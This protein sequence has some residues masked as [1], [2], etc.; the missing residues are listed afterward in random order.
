MAYV[1]QTT[2]Y[3]YD[4]NYNRLTEIATENTGNTET[5]N[6]TFSYNNRNQITDITD[7]RDN[8]NNVVFT[9][10]ENGNRTTKVQNTTTT[11]FDYDIRD[12]IKTITQGGSSVGQFLYDWQGLRIKK[13]TQAETLRYVYDDQSVLVQT[14][15]TG[16]TISKYDYGPDRLLSLNNT[17]EGTQ[18]YLFDA[19]GS[20]VNLI[21]PDGSLQARYQYDAWGNYRSTTGT[22]KNAFGFT[23]HE[24]DEETSLYYA[25]ARFYDPELGLFLNEDPFEGDPLTP[26]SLHRYTYAFANPTVYID[27]NGRE[28]TAFFN[29]QVHPETDILPT[30]GTFDSGFLPLDVVNATIATP[31][32]F[33]STT[34][35]AISAGLAS[36]LIV[37][38]QL[39]GRSVESLENEA[40]ALS[41]STGPLAPFVFAGTLPS[42]LPGTLSRFSRSLRGIDKAR[43]TAKTTPSANQ[44][45]NIADDIPQ[46]PNG[47]SS[48]T[49][50]ESSTKAGIETRRNIDGR[51]IDEKT[52]RFVKENNSNKSEVITPS[53]LYDN[54]TFQ[55]ARSEAIQRSPDCENCG[56]QGANQGDHV[57][58]KGEVAD[59]L[60]E[61]PISLESKRKIVEEIKPE[62]NSVISNLCGGKGGCNPSKGKKRTSLDPN[63]E[64]AFIVNENATDSFKENVEQADQIRL[65]LKILID[66]NK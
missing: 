41:A 21:K 26:P 57:L 50:V 46:L 43:D 38:S 12:Q 54:S 32:N 10:D 40:T 56:A 53:D 49:V 7:N 33:V 22:S 37:T 3:T 15:D 52:G 4:G 8:N 13:Q 17:T 23:G 19:L 16:T 35:N 42:R 39:T 44:I 34:V 2:A 31:V 48:I 64:G 6:K 28:A 14:D 55:K 59:S 9:Y 11:N 27:L 24:L 45:E 20:V 51:L 65:K 25:K 29:L 66:K 62:I 61:A 36:P 47:D 30:F 60:N 5:T 63:D 1:D 58:S 18:F